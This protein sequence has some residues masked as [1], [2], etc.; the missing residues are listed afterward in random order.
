MKSSIKMWST[1]ATFLAAMA[2]PM[3][4][5]AQDNPS[6]DHR[7]RHHTY[8][9]ID[10]GTLGGPA[11]YNGDGGDGVRYLNNHDVVTGTADTPDHDPYDPFCSWPDCQLAHAFRWQHGR[12]ID[13]GSLPGTNGSTGSGINDNGWVTGQ[14]QT[15][16][17][18][19][20]FGSEADPV[21][22]TDHRIIDLGNFGG[23]LGTGTCVNNRGQVAGFALNNIPDDFSGF[24]TQ[25]RAFLWE[26]GHKQDVGTLG[27]GTTISIFFG[28]TCV[29]ELGHVFGSSFTSTIPNPDT[30]IPT[31]DPCLWIRGRM[32][33]LGGLGGTIGGPVAANEHDQIVGLSDLAGDLVSHPFLWSRGRMIDLGTFGGSNGEATGINDDG[34]V[35]GEADFPGDAVHDA[36]L[37]RRGRLIDLGNLGAT[38][39]AHDINSQAQVVGSSRIDATPGNSRAFLSEDAAPIV[40]LNDLIPPHSNFT[41]VAAFN[42]NEG[43][44]IAGTGVPAG[45]LPQD[46]ETCGHAYLL[47]PD[48]DC[49]GNCQNRLDQRQADAALR[50]ES[51]RTTT[52]SFNPRLTPSEHVRGM[53]RQRYGVA[54]SHPT[55]RD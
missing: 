3:G 28:N 1:A 53:M 34:D 27:T 30:G 4:L 8:R 14:S 39:F 22:W 41:L 44:V 46:V 36:F 29:N 38:S 9:L 18:D 20:N 2:M 33:D 7:H 16:V 25:L 32:M 23:P 52:R 26:N 15:G 21:L 11:S 37:W 13:L 50:R 5:V 43:G 55:L 48:G 19:P 47:I 35:I 54:G 49:D 6:P 24:G 45:C 10:L 51:A 40:D 17:L 12:L 42:I 31:V